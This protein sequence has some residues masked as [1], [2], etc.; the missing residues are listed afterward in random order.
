MGQ[1]IIFTILIFYISDVCLFAQANID[2]YPKMLKAD[3]K[4]SCSTDFVMIELKTSPDLEKEIYLGKFYSVANN[5]FPETIKYVYVGRV[6]TCRSGGCSVK[7]Y[8]END[9]ES[10]YFDYYILFDQTITIQLVRIYS[11]KATHGQEITANSWLKQFKGYRGDKE[12]IA[13][14][15]IDAISGAT[16]SV[17][18]INFDVFHKTGL[19]KEVIAAQ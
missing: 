13:N 3:L 8:S 18:A 6:L 11:Y 4:K 14:K 9:K 2:F 12:P 16:I 10:E 17:N 7:K 19:I 15:N 5:V 1:K